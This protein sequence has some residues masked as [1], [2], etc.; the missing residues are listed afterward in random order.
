MEERENSR[1]SEEEVAAIEADMAVK[2]ERAA[3]HGETSVEEK[4]GVP[5]SI[6]EGPER[7]R[8][9]FDPA[10]EELEIEPIERWQRLLV[11]IDE[12]IPKYFSSSSEEDVAMPERFA[13]ELK[14]LAEEDEALAKQIMQLVSTL[15]DIHAGLA[16][17]PTSL[18]GAANVEAQAKKLALDCQDAFRSVIECGAPEFLPADAAGSDGAVST[19]QNQC[20]RVLKFVEEIRQEIMSHVSEETSKEEPVAAELPEE[21]DTADDDDSA[22]E[23]YRPE[24]AAQTP[25][26]RKAAQAAAA[27]AQAATAAAGATAE[28]TE[29][30]TAESEF[31]LHDRITK[32]TDSADE[33]VRWDHMIDKG[34]MRGFTRRQ[35]DGKYRVH[36]SYQVVSWCAA[37]PEKFFQISWKERSQYPTKLQKIKNPD[38]GDFFPEAVFLDAKALDLYLQGRFAEF[39]NTEEYSLYVRK[40]KDH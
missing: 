34:F 27:G 20:A 9:P 21:A 24:D 40:L 29:E 7:Q 23:E 33:W 5:E 30:T 6:T 4:E 8:E 25:I 12:K 1:L 16:K 10:P 38:T 37:D 22:N 3:E 13:E 32:V 26:R 19:I 31:S 17:N 2:Q 35:A 14:L 28:E 36:M 39:P 11:E 18:M 15:E